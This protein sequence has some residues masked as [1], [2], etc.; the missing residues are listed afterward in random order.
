MAFIMSLLEPPGGGL[1]A[2]IKAIDQ[3]DLQKSSCS[4]LSKYTTKELLPKG[5]VAFK[6]EERVLS[7]LAK[8]GLTLE[9]LEELKN[10]GHIHTVEAKL[11]NPHMYADNLTVL[12]PFLAAKVLED[13][14]EARRAELVAGFAKETHLN[15]FPNLMETLSKGESSKLVAAAEKG[16]SAGGKLNFNFVLN[17]LKHV[18]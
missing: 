4:G 7:K 13:I 14:P 15:Q 17:I 10:R 18:H 2:D 3:I 5:S 11:L 1:E 6:S 8:H 16:L 12:H 9:I